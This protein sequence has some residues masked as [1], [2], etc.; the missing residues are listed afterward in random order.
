VANNCIKVT[1]AQ[2]QKR[3]FTGIFPSNQVSAAASAVATCI[4]CG[5]TTTVNTGSPCAMALDASGSGVVSLNGNPTMSLTACDL[6]NNSPDATATTIVGSNAIIEGHPSVPTMVRHL[7]P[8][9]L[10]LRA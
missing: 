4:G 8:G 7:P 9:S 1:I 10:A 6:Y 5:V 3:Y 2:Q